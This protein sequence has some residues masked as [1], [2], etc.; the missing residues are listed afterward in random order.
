MTELRLGIIGA[1]EIAHYTAAEVEHASGVRLH[2]VADINS[3]RAQELAN[4]FGL[5][6]SYTSGQ[7]LLGQSDVDAVY[8]A[9]PN[10]LH[11]PM[12]IQALNAGKHVLL[13]KP[14][15]LNATEAQAVI[16][17]ANETQRLLMLGMNTRFL[18]DV[19]RARALYQQGVLGSVYHIKTHWRR[20]SGIPRIGSWFTD[21]TTAGGGALL[22]IGVHMLDASLFILDN[23]TP[24]S[25]TGSVQNRFGA[26]GLGDGSWGR[27]ERSHRHSNVDDFAVAL[28]RLEGGVT[29]NLEVAWAL[30]QAES[31]TREIELFGEDA[32]VS[33]FAQALHTQ[34]DGQ[35]DLQRQAFTA[36]LQYQH[37]S[38]VQHFADCVLGKD[39]AA[40]T[41]SQALTV[42]RVLDAIYRSAETGAEIVL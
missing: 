2:A 38:R 42:Q 21:R 8:I 11:A 34:S 4:R 33:V 40:V 6:H 1:G 28:I 35:E 26:R 37:A 30:H 3:D 10:A 12:A 15:A 13:E 41:L 23:F 19:Q 29:L 14:F 18:A 39:T 16:S 25:V 36:P 31:E 27:S 5:A 22:D 32:S 9:V 7:S 24:L 17:T 20:R